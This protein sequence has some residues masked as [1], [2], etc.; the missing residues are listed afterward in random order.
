MSFSFRQSSLIAD[1]TWYAIYPRLAWRFTTYNVEFVAATVECF[2]H[3]KKKKILHWKKILKDPWGTC[4]GKRS[5]VCCK[6]TGLRFSI[7]LDMSKDYKTQKNLFS[8]AVAPQ[9][10]MANNDSAVCFKAAFPTSELKAHW[11]TFFWKLIGL[12]IPYSKFVTNHLQATHSWSSCAT[13]KS[14]YLKAM[15]NKKPT[16]IIH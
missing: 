10:H 8:V 1:H 6:D 12:I 16:W 14:S 9:L 2:L 3:S 5:A 13:L 4:S 15:Q 11:P 7:T